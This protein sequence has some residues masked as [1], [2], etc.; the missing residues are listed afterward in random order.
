MSGNLKY[1]FVLDVNSVIPLSATQYAGNHVYYVPDNLVDAYKAAANWST[2][3][4]C[5]RPMSDLPD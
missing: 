1:T 2:I 3:T 4:S 5:I